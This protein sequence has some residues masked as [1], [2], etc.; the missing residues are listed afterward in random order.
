M[1]QRVLLV[2]LGRW[3]A[4]DPAATPWA[5]GRLLHPR[6]AVLATGISAQTHGAAS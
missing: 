2:R 5:G 3:I 4:A 6:G 1:A